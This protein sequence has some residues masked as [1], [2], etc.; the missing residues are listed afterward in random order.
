MH[1]KAVFIWLGTHVM[2]NDLIFLFPISS[3]Y[4]IAHLLPLAMEVEDFTGFY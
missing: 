4:V 3:T 1:I 2:L